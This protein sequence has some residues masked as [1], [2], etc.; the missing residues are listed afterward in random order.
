[1]SQQLDPANHLEVNSRLLV[2]QQKEHGFQMCRQKHVEQTTDDNCQ[3]MDA[4]LANEPRIFKHKHTVIGK[5][6]WILLFASVVDNN[7]HHKVLL[8]CTV[9]VAPP[10]NVQ[11]YLLTY[12]LTVFCIGNQNFS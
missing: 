5:L 8:G 12:S 10:I 3:I 7:E 9:I 11:T 6:S 4:V 2:Q 1:M